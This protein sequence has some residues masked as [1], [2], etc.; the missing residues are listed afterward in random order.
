M[1]DK[2]K[3]R[4]IYVGGLHHIGKLVE[5]GRTGSILFFKRTLLWVLLN[6]IAILLND[7]Y[8]TIL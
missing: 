4:L 5:L 6:Y 2:N 3:I 1:K 7:S 8:Y